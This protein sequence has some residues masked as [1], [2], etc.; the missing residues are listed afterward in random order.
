MHRWVRKA[1]CWVN[2][3]VG[4]WLPAGA[5]SRTVPG[6]PGPVH[7]DDQMYRSDAPE[8]V[9]HYVE[10]ARSA[11]ENIEQSLGAV[12]R[13][14]DDVR[15]CLDFA[16]GYGRVTRWLVRALGPERVIAADLDRQAIRFCSHAFG[17]STVRSPCDPARV[18]NRDSYDVVFVGSLLTHLPVSGCAAALRALRGI[19]RPD[20]ILIL[21]TQGESCLAHLDWYGPEFVAAADEFRTGVRRDG[22]AFV[23]YRGRRDYGI[24]ILTPRAVEALV[25][26]DA[27]PALRLVRFVERGWDRHQDVWSYQRAAE[28]TVTRVRAGSPGA[29]AFASAPGAVRSRGDRP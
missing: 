29:F 9:R 25:E 7:V 4:R 8:H 5:L 17:I 12:G 26:Q 3:T 21:S 28:S 10:D 2:R 6:I 24:T 19:V 22:A 18:A 13:S 11:M 14:F 27:E 15:S 20:G 23:P 16:C 1:L